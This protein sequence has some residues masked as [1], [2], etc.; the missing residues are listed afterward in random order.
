MITNLRLSNYRSIASLSNNLAKQNLIIAPNGTGKTNILEAIYFSVFG[1]S[2]RTIGSRSEIIKDSENITSVTLES[3]INKLVVSLHSKPRLV[4]YSKLNGKS[5]TAFQRVKAFPLILFAPHSVDLVSG[6]P[7]IRRND[8]DDFLSTCFKSYSS[9]IQRYNKVLKNR[10]ALLKNI[11]IGKSA[12][13]ELSYWNDQFIETG[14]IV[15]QERVLFFEDIIP[16]I[17]STAEKL[18]HD[19]KSLVPIYVPNLVSDVVQFKDVFKNKLDENQE[20]EI[21][22]GRSLYGIHK[23]DFEFHLNEKN[24]R[25]FASRGQQRLASFILKL[26]QHTYLKEVFNYNI[27]FLIDDIMSELDEEHRNNIAR[28]LLD[29]IDQFILTGPDEKEVPE[30]LKN[31]SL[32]ININ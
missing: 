6:Q 19:F 3:E 12:K 7:G 15:F 4:K 1:K 30:V 2:F 25:Y 27:T 22:V 14:F 23:D 5:T 29:Y 31:K 9:A 16:F 18:Y 8:L 13:K 24:V 11:K 10:N 21:I 20:K 26:A 17:Q 32:H 28:Y